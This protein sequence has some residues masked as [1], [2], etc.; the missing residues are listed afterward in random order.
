MQGACCGRLNARRDTVPFTN[1]VSEIH[2]QLCIAFLTPLTPGLHDEVGK[3][4][5]VSLRQSLDLYGELQQKQM[6]SSF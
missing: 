4:K 6:E 1:S 5:A 3:W 2:R